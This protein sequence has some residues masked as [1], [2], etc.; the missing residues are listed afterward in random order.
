MTMSCEAFLNQLNARAD[1]E[2]PTDDAA[3]LDAHLAECPQCRAVAEALRTIDAELRSAFA[4]RREAAARL[5]ESTVAMVRAAAV[6]PVSIAPP[7]APAP[8]FAWR[9]ALVGLAAGFLLALALFR[10]WRSK[11]DAPDLL[12]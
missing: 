12:T 11:P 7:L 3:G 9:Q 4:G 2:L 1:G 6:A 8:S 5:A 10:P